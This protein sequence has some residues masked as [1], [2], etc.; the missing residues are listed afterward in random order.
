MNDQ[1]QYQS[2]GFD[3]ENGTY[4]YSYMPQ[5]QSPVAPSEPPKTKKS[6]TGLKVIAMIL[7][8]A[9]VGGGTGVGGAALYDSLR[10]EVPVMA[11]GVTIY[12]NQTDPIPVKVNQADGLTPMS[13]SEIYAAYANACVCNH[14]TSCGVRV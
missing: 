2:G 6:R 9:L 3:R 1:N 4:H 13:L 8:C 11:P 10:E 12:Q 14:G 7:C 5:Y